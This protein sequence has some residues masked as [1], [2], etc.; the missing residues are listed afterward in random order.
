[1]FFRHNCTENTHLFHEQITTFEK[2]TDVRGMDPDGNIVEAFF[3]LNDLLPCVAGWEVWTQHEKANK[4][5][6]EAKK[7]V[8]VLDEAFTILALKTTGKGGIAL[9]RQ[10]E[11]TQGLVTIST[12]FGQ[13]QPT[14]NFMDCAN[15]LG[16]SARVRQ[17]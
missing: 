9:E 10:Y 11:V 6:S 12:W 15:E 2:V 8:S 14:F 16:N 5:I 17:T 3:F 13:M 4:V 7:V 1:M